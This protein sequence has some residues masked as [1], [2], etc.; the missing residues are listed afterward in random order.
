MLPIRAPHLLWRRRPQNAV[1]H[2]QGQRVA[3]F[4]VALAHPALHRTELRH[5]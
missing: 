2:A 1:E 4:G 3:P 5:L